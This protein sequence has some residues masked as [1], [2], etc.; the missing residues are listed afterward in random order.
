M[1]KS[2]PALI[3]TSV[4]SP[5]AIMKTMAQRCVKESMDFIVIGDA[6]SP[7]EFNLE[8]CRYYSLSEQKKL[9][10][11]L[12][13]LLPEKHYARKNIGYLLAKDSA[14]II[15]TDDDNM[16][17]EA[18]WQHRLQHREAR[19]VTE[20]GWVNIYRFFSGE[21]IWP[22]GFPLEM[23]QRPSSMATGQGSTVNAP[24]QQGLCD[25]DP[26]IDAISRLTRK[27][28]IHFHRN[29]QFSLGENSWCPFNSQNTTWFK[30]S[31]PLLYL[32]S[33]CSFRMTDIW[34][35]FIAQRIAW[36]CGWN[37]LYHEATM[38]QERNAHDLL[39]D[40]EDEIPGY[41]Y[42]ARICEQLED[43][44]LKGGIQNLAENLI[45]CYRMMTEQKYF[46]NDELPLVDAWI[47]DLN[48]ANRG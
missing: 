24:I 6:A 14:L 34:R 28:P 33:T 10:F 46:T 27:H 36:T 4:A 7:S 48:D 35:S 32:P 47:H 37:I 38:Q 40:F 8:G 20:A 16:P 22:R 19:T 23:I 15:E 13:G 9:G 30:D 41:L 12:A 2:N 39:K 21:A 44:D 18:F 45:R 29:G 17:R 1:D 3:I 5:N 25:I 26:D 43:L 31:F 42:N 11:R